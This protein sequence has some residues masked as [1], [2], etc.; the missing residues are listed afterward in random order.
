M[1]IF[2]EQAKESTPYKPKIW[3]RDVDD[4]F[5]ILDHSSVD[6]FLHHLNSQQPTICF[7][8]GTEK[9][10]K[11]A[12][13]DKNVSREPDGHFTISVCRKPTHTDQYLAYDSHHPQSIKRASV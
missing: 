2:E 3:K 11:I 12:F 6:S 13:L 4:T 7:T 1:E 5:T 8:V 9:E 10:S